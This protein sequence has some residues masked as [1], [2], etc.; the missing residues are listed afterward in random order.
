MVSLSSSCVKSILSLLGDSVISKALDWVVLPRKGK[1]WQAG[2]DS[3][4]RVRQVWD[5]LPVFRVKAWS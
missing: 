3:A 4:P 5:Q 2:E 1:D